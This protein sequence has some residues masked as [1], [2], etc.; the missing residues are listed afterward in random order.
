MD[1]APLI[2]VTFSV[3]PTMQILCAIGGAIVIVYGIARVIADNDC[4]GLR[5]VV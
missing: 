5:Q 1:L 4:D 3:G 2:C